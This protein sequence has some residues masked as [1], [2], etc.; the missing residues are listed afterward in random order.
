MRSLLIYLFLKL[1]AEV[2]L[3]AGLASVVVSDCENATAIIALAV[4]V[5]RSNLY[6]DILPVISLEP[7]VLA[8]ALPLLRYLAFLVLHIL[9]FML[10]SH[11][12]GHLCSKDRV[13]DK[14]TACRASVSAS[15]VMRAYLGDVKVTGGAH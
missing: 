9:H 7:I 5:A 14:R 3:V 8:C 1:F 12:Y 10:D 2:E 11:H 13:R 6:D 15:T 4:P